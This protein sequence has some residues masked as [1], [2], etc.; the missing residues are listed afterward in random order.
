MYE[1]T[2][3]LLGFDETKNVKLEKLDDYFST[4]ILD[5]E[6]LINFTIVNIKYLQHAAFDFNIEDEI[7]EKMHIRARED[8]DIYF[9]V[10]LQD[11]IEKSIVNLV[12]PILINKRHNLIG[13]YII[14]DKIPKLFTNLRE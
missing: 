2:I 4:L 11:P 1:I 10:V 13:Q 6:N 14:K 5:K 7:L 3:P 8:F 9:S 12:A